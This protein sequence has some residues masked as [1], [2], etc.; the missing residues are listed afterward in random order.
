MLRVLLGMILLPFLL[1]FLLQLTPVQNALIDYTTQEIN[2]SIDGEVNIDHIDLSITKGLMLEGF[3]LFEK[4][5]DTIVVA[6]ALNVDLAASLYSLF[7][8][9]IAIKKVSL[10]DPNVRII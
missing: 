4:T 10:D 8:N 5:G 1:F 2:K 9:E 3:S 7:D 6:K